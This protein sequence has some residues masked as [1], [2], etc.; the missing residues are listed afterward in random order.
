MT[1]RGKVCRPDLVCP[2]PA[3][4][5]TPP[6]KEVL[7]QIIEGFL[8]QHPPIIWLELRRSLG[9][10]APVA[11]DDLVRGGVLR[12]IDGKPGREPGPRYDLTAKGRKLLLNGRRLQPGT[13]AIDIP[14]GQF[15][16]VPRSAGL[17]RNEIGWPDVTFKYSFVANANAAMLLRI[18]PAIDWVIADYHQPYVNLSRVGQEAEQTLPLEFCYGRWIVRKPSSHGCRTP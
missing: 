8:A 17:D 15:L 9:S 4:L 6:S 12:I 11:Y 16:Y 1:C 14:V 3:P 2:T 13:N 7:A 18:G 10:Y 5:P